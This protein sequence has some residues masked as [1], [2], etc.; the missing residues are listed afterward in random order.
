MLAK[1]Y[2]PD[3]IQNISTELTPMVTT[4]RYVKERHPNAKVTFIGPCTAKKLEASRHSVRSDVDF[5]L[6]YEE[7][8]GMFVAKGIEFNTENEPTTLK[9]ARLRQRYGVPVE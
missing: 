1:K 7:L 6:T 4:A 2:F 9:D 8:M 3:I 5:V